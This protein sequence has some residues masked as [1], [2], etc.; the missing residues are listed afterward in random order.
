MSKSDPDSAIFMED[1]R[2]DIARKL[3][4]AFC[5]TSSAGGP[6]KEADGEMRLVVDDIENPCLDYVRCVRG[7]RERGGAR[8]VE[9]TPKKK[10]AAAALRDDRAP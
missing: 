4:N 8:A 1:S 9:D 6:A 10:W 5:P 3:G 2:A 7:S